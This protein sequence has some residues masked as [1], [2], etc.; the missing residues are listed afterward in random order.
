MV[1]VVGVYSSWVRVAAR[2][3]IQAEYPHHLSQPSDHEARR[4]LAW[5]P[6]P[7]GLQKVIKSHYFDSRKAAIPLNSQS[8]VLRGRHTLFR[9]GLVTHSD[10]VLPQSSSR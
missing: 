6:S 8:S 2:L 7:R 5:G 9:H 1:V 3:E 4:V 10:Q